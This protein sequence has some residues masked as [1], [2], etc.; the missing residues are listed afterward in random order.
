M[1]IS[2]SVNGLAF[3]NFT[4]A[5]VKIALDE[6]SG[7]FLFTAVST[8]GQRLPFE[9]GDACKILVNGQA[10]IDGF[11]EKLDYSYS[12]QAHSINVSGRDKTADL[13]DSTINGIKLSP[14]ISLKQAIKKVLSDI[15]ATAIDVIDSVGVQNFSKAEEKLSGSV[16]QNA[17]EFCEQLAR[18]RQVLLTRSA[19]NIEITNGS[20]IDSGASVQNLIDSDTNNILSASVSYDLTQ[21]FG[22]YIVKSQLNP[23]ALNYAGETPAQ[24]VTQQSGQ[25]VDKNVRQSRQLVI[26][27]ENSSSSEQAR[28]RAIWS[29]N[30]RKA[31]GR[32]YSCTVEGFE[33]SVGNLYSPNQLIQVADEF[34]EISAKMLLNSVEFT[35]DVEGGSNSNLS[36][37]DSNAYT[38]ELSEPQVEKV[39]AA[40]IP[41]FDASRI[42][43]PT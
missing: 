37:V 14:P 7:S 39:G 43:R 4:S 20:G 1:T 17:F 35:F 29:A 28:K 15:G 10:V 2:I 41:V 21:R 36:F 32:I 22:K 12:D 11:I 5:T 16:G 25:T 27:A 24:E 30:I 18:K 34:A 26:K 8:E 6:I 3:E 33:N 19:G 40:S 42:K 9:N 23:V 31:R 13:I 38:L